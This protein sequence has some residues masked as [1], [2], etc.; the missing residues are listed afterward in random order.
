MF[1][2]YTSFGNCEHIINL[3]LIEKI[4]LDRE[5]KIIKIISHDN[6]TETIYQTDN[7]QILNQ[8]WKDFNNYL[9]MGEHIFNFS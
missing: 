7:E 4:T 8:K 6:S 1:I 3:D 9:M 2:R 5:N